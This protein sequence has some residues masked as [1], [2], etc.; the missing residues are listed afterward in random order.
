MDRAP[1][2][3]LFLPI[4]AALAIAA[5]AGPPLDRGTPPSPPPPPASARPSP[6]AAP[7]SLDPA[8][9][10]AIAEIEHLSNPFSTYLTRDPPPV[11]GFAPIPA[12]RGGRFPGAGYAEVRGYAYRFVHDLL[13]GGEDARCGGGRQAVLTSKGELCP[14][15]VAPGVKLSEE[16][17]ARLVALAEQPDPEV[18]RIVTRCE[19]DPHH[20]FVF[21]DARGVPVAELLVCFSCGQWDLLPA[22]SGV[23]ELMGK[24]E[25]E[26][27]RLCEE[28]KLGGCHLGDDAF[29][30]KIREARQARRAK[31]PAPRALGLPAALGIDGSTPLKDLSPQ[32]RWATCLASGHYTLSRTSYALAQGFQ[33]ENDPR[34]GRFTH[35]WECRDSFPS[36][37]VPLERVDA[38]WPRFV[39]DPCKTE[40]ETRALCEGLD[41]CLPRLEWRKAAP[42][43]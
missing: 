3:F 4:A 21:Y 30:D 7:P 34:V 37:D 28:L 22:P 42:A 16:Q 13:R 24:N 39:E 18:R 20:A 15:V 43:R 32:Q 6:S 9:E 29:T 2:L 23:S 8:V 5:C 33:C 19:F 12:K 14:T 17:A 11:R 26:L 35:V 1:L 31:E 41:G 40:A 25:P 38:C 10:K 27:R 36:C